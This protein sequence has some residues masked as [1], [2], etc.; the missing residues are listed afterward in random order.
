MMVKLIKRET[1]GFIISNSTA[2]ELQ[3]AMN[4]K[5]DSGLTIS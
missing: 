5:L 2:Y 1:K 3:E 4:V